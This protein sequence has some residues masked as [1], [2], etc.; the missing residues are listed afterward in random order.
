MKRSSPRARL[1]L[2]EDDAVLAQLAQTLLSDEGFEVVVCSDPLQAHAFV[3]GEQ[4]DLVLL[5]LT[6]GDGTCGWRV[7]DHLKFDPSTSRTPV[8]LWSG[9]HEAQR[10]RALA[11]LPEQGIFVMTK[12]FEFEALLAAVEDALRQ[13][14]PLLRLAGGQR[15][16]DVV[17]EGGP[18][19]LTAREQ[20]VA[21][22]IARGYTNRQI[23]DALVLT[24]GTVANYVAHILD[25]LD[26]S[27]RVQI[28]TWTLEH[29]PSKRARD[30]EGPNRRLA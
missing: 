4:P 8:I 10:A 1:A 19:G 11:A 24:P 5:N 23:A 6:L 3:V 29:G 9:A 13:Y 20:E 2:V 7:L 15:S 18:N 27:T 12:P 16:G 21:R 22:L 28:A 30:N 26:C 17:G 14:P 25:K